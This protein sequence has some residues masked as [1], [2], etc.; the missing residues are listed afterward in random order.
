MKTII[1]R[2]LSLQD[3]SG[4]VLVRAGEI[5][6]HGEKSNRLARFKG[7]GGTKLTPAEPLP[8]I[9]TREAALSWD[10]KNLLAADRSSR[11]IFQVDP[12]S[13]KETPVMEPDSLSFGDFDTA[14]LTPDAIIG[15]TAWYNGLLYLA[16]QA[17]YSSAIYGID[18]ENKQVVSHRRAPGPKPSGLDFNPKDGSMYII[19]NRNRELRK[20]ATTGKEDV[21]DIPDE[22]I[23]P[24]GLSFESERRLWS[25]DWS[26]GDVLRIRMEE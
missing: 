7:L 2:R 5:W 17:G 26:T 15:D 10:G 18:L 23:E 11:K 4:T 20:F 22:W 8:S 19:D 25:T 3:R 14:L 12:S 24:R 21:A 16:V 13:G 1:E 9:T 6:T